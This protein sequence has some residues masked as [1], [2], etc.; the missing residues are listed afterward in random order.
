[1]W[2]R[3]TPHL[4]DADH[5]PLGTLLAVPLTLSVKAIL[6]DADPTAQWLR[7]LFCDQPRQHAGDVV[8]NWLRRQTCD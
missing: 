1:M 6:M 3:L 5:R 8:T 4:L 2:V 7:P